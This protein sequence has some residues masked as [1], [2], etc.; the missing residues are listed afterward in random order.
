MP[1]FAIDEDAP[2]LVE[3][4]PEPGLQQ[5]SFSPDDLVEKSAWALDSAMNTIHHMAQRV[6][7]MIETLPGRPNQVEVEFGLKLDAETGAVIA[8]AGVEAAVNVRL[9]WESD[10]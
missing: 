9:A 7:A 5:V 8:K 6:N 2:I 4:A 1:T 10:G 3:F